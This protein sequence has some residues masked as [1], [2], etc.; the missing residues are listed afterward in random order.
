MDEEALDVVAPLPPE[1]IP[2]NQAFAIN[3]YKGVA[4]SS[5][6]DLT[7]QLLA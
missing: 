7:P 6:S 1:V 3:P 4:A 5:S 2:P